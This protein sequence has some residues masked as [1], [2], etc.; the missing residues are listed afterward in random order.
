MLL[1][2]FPRASAPCQILAQ[3][4]LAGES[5]VLESASTLSVWRTSVL[6][7][8]SASLDTVRVRHAA[9]WVRPAH[10]RAVL[11]TRKPGG[12]SQGR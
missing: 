10:E 8:R 7:L 5:D 11:L 6:Q 2:D 9:I 1:G 4:I 3:I 12:G